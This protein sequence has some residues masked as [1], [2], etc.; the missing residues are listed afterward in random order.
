MKAN[1]LALKKDE[2]DCVSLYQAIF[3]IA[4][5]LKAAEAALEA[6]MAASFEAGMAASVEAEMAASFDDEL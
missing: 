2:Y 3:D 6:G 1:S 5:M 4:A